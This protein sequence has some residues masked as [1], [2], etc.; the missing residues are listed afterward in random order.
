MIYIIKTQVHALG[1]QNG[2]TMNPWAVSGLYQED[3][4]V[5]LQI[6]YPT[7]N[8][9]WS[10]CCHVVFFCCFSSTQ[11]YLA[12]IYAHHS[13]FV[14]SGWKQKVHQVQLL[15]CKLCKVSQDICFSEISHYPPS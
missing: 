5:H 1:I 11:H 4:R 3:E 9:C 2:S 10:L 6:Y 13:D 12:E 8:Y 15:I 14:V 7:G